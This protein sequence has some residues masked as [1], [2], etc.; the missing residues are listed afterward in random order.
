MCRLT[1]LHLG[2]L[3]YL[4]IEIK[5]SQVGPGRVKL[6][7][8]EQTGPNR[9]KVGQTGSN[10]VKWGQTG[11]NGAKWGK[12]GQIGPNGAKRG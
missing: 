7:Q 11:S 2:T 1:T 12:R 8:L 5:N 9:A 10:G 3:K 6:G 4:E